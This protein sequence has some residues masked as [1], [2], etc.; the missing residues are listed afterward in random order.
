MFLA[1]CT[2]NSFA[3]MLNVYYHDPVARQKVVLVSPGYLAKEI[4]LLPYVVV[5]WPTV[6][7]AQKM[8]KVQVESERRLRQYLEREK[9]KDW[10]VATVVMDITPTWAAKPVHLQGLEARKRMLVTA[11]GESEKAEFQED[12]VCTSEDTDGDCLD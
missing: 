5:E 7:A 2:D 4:A 6:F 8:P 9:A 11:R 10:F 12:D 3:R 1:V